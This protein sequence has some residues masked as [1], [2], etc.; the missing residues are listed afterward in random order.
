MSPSAKAIR[1]L[2]LLRHAEAAYGAPGVGDHDRPL[3]E[4]GRRQAVAVGQVLAT[5]DLEMVLCSTAAR[6]VE[7]AQVA[8]LPLALIKKPDLYE[9]SAMRIRAVVA[10]IPEYVTKVLVIAHSPG[11]PDLVRTLADAD[12][13]AAAREAIR[14]T[15]PPGSL[16]GL[17]FAGSWT[18]LHKA[19]LFLAQKAA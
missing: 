4:R 17:E 5:K 10:R 18:D 7:T 16:A 15:F 11:I 14:Y 8:K 1:K 2:Y 9:A 3:A 6:A 12:S 19:R 13:D